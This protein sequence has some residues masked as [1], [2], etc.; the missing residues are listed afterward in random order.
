MDFADLDEDFFAAATVYPR[1]WQALDCNWK[2]RGQDGYCGLCA[3]GFEA[4]S[5]ISMRSASAKERRQMK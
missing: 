3:L 1:T 4:V 5:V 2:Y